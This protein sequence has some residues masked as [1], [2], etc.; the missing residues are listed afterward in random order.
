MTVLATQAII[1]AQNGR[2]VQGD[3]LRAPEVTRIG[4]RIRDPGSG[5][6][7]SDHGLPATG[8]VPRV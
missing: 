2:P 3:G 8:Y 6:P 4:I 5:D 7:G 1:D